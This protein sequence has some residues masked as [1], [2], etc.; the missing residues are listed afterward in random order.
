M[1]KEKIMKK[2]VI[3]LALTAAVCCQ[4]QN[5]IQNGDFQ[6]LDNKGKLAGWYYRVN[7]YS[8]VPSDRPGETGKKVITTKVKLPT[9]GKTIRASTNLSQRIRDVK[10]GKYV[11]SVT[12]KV[13]GRGI[14]NCSWSFFDQQGKRMKMKSPYWT[15]PCQSSDWSTIT[16][17]LEI[18]EGVGSMNFTV[19]SYLDTRFKHT[20]ST[21]FISQ[22]S[23]TPAGEKPAAKKD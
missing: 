15:P 20:D 3:A 12:A 2:T 16:F 14:V 4:A 6:A 8:Q 11:V 19:T 9:D 21:M 23:L 10:P 17:D 18:P 5:L 7:E 1:N 22:V 13:V